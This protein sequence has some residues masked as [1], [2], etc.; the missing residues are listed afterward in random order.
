MKVTIK[1]FVHALQGLRY[2]VEMSKHF[3]V[4]EYRVFP[5]DMSKYGEGVL[6]GE[7]DIEIDVP[8]NFDIRTE[9]IHNLESKKKGLMAD[10][11]KRV[12]EIDAKIQSLLAI[13]G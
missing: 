12:S 4:V 13:E 10:F 11:N 8:S 5:F 2:N 6:V 9:L 3:D 1:C 7:Q